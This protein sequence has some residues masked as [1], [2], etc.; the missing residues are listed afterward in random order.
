MDLALIKPHYEWC[1]DLHR[2]DCRVIVDFARVQACMPL[3]SQQNEHI[4][5]IIGLH[6]AFPQFIIWN[7]ELYNITKLS[8]KF[9]PTH[10]LPCTLKSTIWSLKGCIIWFLLQSDQ[11]SPEGLYL[12]PYKDVSPG[13]KEAFWYTQSRVY[14]CIEVL[15][16][17]NSKRLETILSVPSLPK[18]SFL[19]NLSYCL[20]ASATV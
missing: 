4:K 15:H 10:F 6:T 18:S 19:N 12:L 11:W 16:L 13:S 20:T 3:F 2:G 17:G 7:E 8:I 1:L 5:K 9:S 14:L